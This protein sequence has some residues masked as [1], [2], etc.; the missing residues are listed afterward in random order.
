MGCSSSVSK[1]EIRHHK[2][3]N[4]VEHEL[5]SIE[6]TSTETEDH[7]NLRIVA[8][9]EKSIEIAP[10]MPSQATIE[11]APVIPSTMTNAAAPDDSRSKTSTV[12]TSEA[13]KK[14]LFVRHQEL[15]SK[16]IGTGKLLDLFFL[17]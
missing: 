8:L 3:A 2:S 12:K 14:Q 13:A 16:V 9:E 15:L 6:T 7:S 4:I 10:A 1:S 5:S 17:F 11:I